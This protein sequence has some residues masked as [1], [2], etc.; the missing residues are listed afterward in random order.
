MTWRRVD[1]YFAKRVQL[2][3]F[4]VGV[5][6]GLDYL[7][8]PQGSSRALT[9]I[10]QSIVPLW[11]WGVVIMAAGLTGFITEWRFLGNEHPAMTSARRKKWGWVSNICHI[12]LFAILCV[13]AASALIDI[14]QRFI[15]TGE[16]YGWRTGL[17]WGGY[18]YINWEF[19]RRLGDPE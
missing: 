4:A 19:I 14:V 7:F 3:A 2:V 12:T 8:T 17:L 16:L 5:F 18:A 10:E 11:L 13:L 1:P 9:Y 6:F 15:H